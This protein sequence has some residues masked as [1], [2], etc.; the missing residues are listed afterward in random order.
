MNLN[1]F[2]AQIFP[3]V[4]SIAKVFAKYGGLF[5]VLVSFLVVIITLLIAYGAVKKKRG[6]SK[7]KGARKTVKTLPDVKKILGF[8]PYEEIKTENASGNF[9]ALASSVA[10]VEDAIELK[11][12]QKRITQ[13]RISAIL[14]EQ[15]DAQE[16]KNTC[17]D[18]ISAL[19]NELVYEKSKKRHKNKNRIADIDSEIKNNVINI[20][21]YESDVEFCANKIAICKDALE[22]LDTQIKNLEVVMADKRENL[23][24]AENKNGTTYESVKLY[25]KG[26]KI[27][28]ENPK[29]KEPLLAYIKCRYNMEKL[30]KRYNIV[31]SETNLAK[32]EVRQ[33]SSML[34]ASSS[35]SSELSK[36][37][38]QKNK[39]IIDNSVKIATLKEELEKASKEV[40]ISRNNATAV[41][42][43]LGIS[44]ESFI[45]AQDSLLALYK[46]ESTSQ[47]LE[48]DV[49]KAKTRLSVL[50]K[51]YAVEKKNYEKIN[52]KDIERK[53]E[54]SR[55][56]SDIL[57]K[58]DKTK[59]EIYRIENFKEEYPKMSP[60]AFFRGSDFSDVLTDGKSIRKNVY[61]AEIEKIKNEYAQTINQSLSKE[62]TLAR[63]QQLLTRLETLEKK[64]Y[65]EKTV[66]RTRAITRQFEN[67][68]GV[69]NQRKV[70]IVEELQIYKNEIRNIDSIYGAKEYKEKLRRFSSTLSE[71][72]LQDPK[73]VA[74]IKKCLD[75]ATLAGEIAQSSW[76]N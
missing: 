76:K 37:I 67:E 14:V 66:L 22:Y 7:K 60:V 26:N 4:S 63:Q 10:S 55:R 2:S 50:Q 13:E 19:K 61:H 56:V 47:R 6:E 73:I 17:N 69:V 30:M 51:E 72:D 59:K 71:E 16:R 45:Y 49:A 1:I 32:N 74:L 8:N 23:N 68:Y 36:K 44:N 11:K 64:I 52:K 39:E 57:N 43:E 54:S 62:E 21:N 53:T 58:I 25:E 34:T 42:S 12:E 3:Y 41:M 5:I 31:S 27:V 70:K 9:Y 65:A 20:S 18:V 40:E 35:S 28:K 75:E 33:M 15:S 46:Y 29:I 24:T 48:L 38:N